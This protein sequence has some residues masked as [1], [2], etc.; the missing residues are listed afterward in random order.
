[1]PE[2]QE[3]PDERFESPQEQNTAGL[4]A[5]SDEQFF[6]SMLNQ[7]RE[8][9]ANEAV[10]PQLVEFVRSKRL[11][12]QFSF[13]NLEELVRFVIENGRFSQY[14]FEK[15]A[16]VEFVTSSLYDDPNG[17]M[18]CEKLWSAIIGRIS[19]PNE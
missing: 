9:M 10:F 19:A 18:N 8:N 12:S 5:E 11:P 6:E 14:E 3:Q 4:N 2:N 1:M 7:T 15:E 17:R 13:E 16:C